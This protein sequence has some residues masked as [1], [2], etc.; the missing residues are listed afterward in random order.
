MVET[1][2]CWTQTSPSSDRLVLYWSLMGN[3]MSLSCCLFSVH[4]LI[5]WFWG[6][7]CSLLE[8]QSVL[9]VFLHI[10]LLSCT[11]HMYWIVKVC[12]WDI[13][14]VSRGWYIIMSCCVLSFHSI[15]PD[16]S[17][18]Y[19]PSSQEE[20]LCNESIPLIKCL[21]FSRRCRSCWN[22]FFSDFPP[23]ILRARNEL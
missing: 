5:S 23:V 21:N 15:H 3:T 8:H 13:L 2:T 9:D 4:S 14:R 6:L 12:V 22:H 11:Q 20:L 10:K 1:K 7:L 16:L 18:S 17:S 19:I